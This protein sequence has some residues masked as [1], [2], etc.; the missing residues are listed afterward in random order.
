MTSLTECADHV[1]AQTRER[2]RNAVSNR[3][4]LLVKEVAGACFLEGIDR[5]VIEV[6]RD[7]LNNSDVWE[8]VR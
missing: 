2:Y 6:R 7:I 3:S 8:R 4:Y 1:R 5:R